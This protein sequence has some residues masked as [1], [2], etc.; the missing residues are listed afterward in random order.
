M[1]TVME[2]FKTTGL[3]FALEG[4][5][6]ELKGADMWEVGTTSR[7]AILTTEK[8]SQYPF[9]QLSW[10]NVFEDLADRLISIHGGLFVLLVTVG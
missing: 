8:P 6:N 9:W 3:G 1:H 4:W 7:A 5:K 10:L 2:Q